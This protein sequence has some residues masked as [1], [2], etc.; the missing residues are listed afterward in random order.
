MLEVIPIEH[1][2]A[3]VNLDRYNLPATKTLGVLWLASSDVFSFRAADLPI[4]TPLPKRTIQS[5]VATIFGPLGFLSPFIDRV[6]IILQELWSKGLRWDDA[7]D[8]HGYSRITTWL[9]ELELLQTITIPRG[10][11]HSLHVKSVMILTFVNASN[12]AYGAVSY[13]RVVHDDE[14]VKVT[15]IASKTQVS[16]FT[17]TSTPRVKQLAAVLGLRLT[18]SM[19]RSLGML[20]WEVR[21]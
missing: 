3:E 16:P 14:S 19:I 21:F 17:P 5:E 20:S 13:F 8:A 18:V 11:Q 7:I 4:M 10:L 2:A 9:V 1:R 6:K 15:I 12:D